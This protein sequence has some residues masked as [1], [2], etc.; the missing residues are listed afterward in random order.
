MTSSLLK[1][2]EK[3]LSDRCK[4]NIFI[5]SPGFIV[6]FSIFGLKKCIQKVFTEIDCTNFSENKEIVAFLCHFLKTIR[7]NVEQLKGRFIIANNFN[8]NGELIL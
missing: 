1:I 7:N 5:K 2:T 4:F 6:R 3:I 8:N